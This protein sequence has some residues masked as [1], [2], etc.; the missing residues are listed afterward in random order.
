MNSFAQQDVLAAC[1][2]YG[3]QLAVTAPLDGVKVMIAIAAVESG[4]GD[5][6]FIGNDCGPRHEPAYEA[7]GAAWA[8]KAMAPLLAVYPPIGAPPQSPAACSYGPWQMMFCNF[9]SATPAE[10]ESNL[11]LCARNFLR[12]FNAYVIGSQKAKT[13]A[14]IGEVW[15][16]G[17]KGPDPAYVAKLQIAYDAA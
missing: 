1:E 5:V 14:D 7:N 15:N 11:D 17:H 4:G 12:F 8:Q 16:M 2:F 3:D 13:L 6:K 9:V 10:L